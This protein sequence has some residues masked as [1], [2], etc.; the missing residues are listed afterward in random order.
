MNEPCWT[1]L[2]LDLED[3]S[4]RIDAADNPNAI[5]LALA[6]KIMECLVARADTLSPLERV[7]FGIA[8]DLLPTPWLRMTWAHVYSVCTVSDAP[9]KVGKPLESQLVPTLSELHANLINALASINE[10]LVAESSARSAG[11]T[12]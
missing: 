2:I 12:G 8:I 11:N 9:E 3:I 6:D 5:R 7:N 10:Q 4:T 1:G